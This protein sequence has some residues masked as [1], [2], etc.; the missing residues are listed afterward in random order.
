M[1]GKWI[2]KEIGV[3]DIEEGLKMTPA[4][5][6][7][8]SDDPMMDE[9]K[10]MACAVLV[11]S[12]DGTANTYVNLPEE[13]LEQAKAEGASVTEYGILVE[14]KELKVENGEFFINTGDSGEVCGEAIDPF[15]KLELDADGC[16]TFAGMFRYTK[17]D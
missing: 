4:A 11:L 2:V 15:V 8:A 7:L 6:I 3:F 13:I 12:E 16:F 5:E 17:A 9:Y 10:Q 1:Y 14:S